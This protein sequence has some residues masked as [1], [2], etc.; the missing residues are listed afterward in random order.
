MFGDPVPKTPLPCRNEG[1][2]NCRT[3]ATL[4]SGARAQDRYCKVQLSG[5]GTI[6]EDWSIGAV[7]D[8]RHSRCKPFAASEGWRHFDSEA[9]H[10]EG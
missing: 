9:P 5:I 7:H 4:S 8:R 2:F 1:P 10:A 6:E 3:A